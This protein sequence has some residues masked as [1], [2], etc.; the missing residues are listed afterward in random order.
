LA[1][2]LLVSAEQ[3]PGACVPAAPG[4]VVPAVAGAVGTGVATKVGVPVISGWAPEVFGK[5]Q[6]AVIIMTMTTAH[7]NTW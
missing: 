3:V 1:A 2:S 5:V 7:R 4:G 6:P